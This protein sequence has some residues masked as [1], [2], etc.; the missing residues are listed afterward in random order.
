MTKSQ[1]KALGFFLIFFI[2][3]PSTKPKKSI[4]KLNKKINRNAKKKKCS[5]NFDQVLME[6]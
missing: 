5:H 1:K 6:K 4:K 2:K 3:I